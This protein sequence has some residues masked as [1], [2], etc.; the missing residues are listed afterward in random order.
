MNSL[1]TRI[2]LAIIAV[3]LVIVT[4]V[5]F[6]TARITDQAFRTYLLR[7][8]HPHVEDLHRVLAHHY[9]TQGS[10]EGVHTT[11]RAYSRHVGRQPS[12]LRRPEI[13]LTDEKGI[14]IVGTAGIRPGQL[15]PRALRSLGTPIVVDDRTVGWLIVLPPGTQ[16]AR[17]PLAERSFL[18]QIQRTLVYIALLAVALGILL[19]VV[20]TRTITSPLQSLVRAARTL[21]QRDF[22]HRVSEKGPEEVAAVARAFNEMA[23][24]LEAAEKRQR[25][26]IADIAHELRTPLSVLQAN[27]RA[28]LDGVYPL[29]PKEIA[30][31]YDEAR[32]INRLV[33]DLHILALA[34]IGQLPLNKETVDVA[35]L[36]RQTTATFALAAE[37]RGVRVDTEIEPVPLLVDVD[38]DRLAQVVRNLLS[39]ALRH[40][41]KGG[42]ITV[43]ARRQDGHVRLEVRDTGPGIPPEHV[44]HVFDRFWRGDPSRARDTGGSGLGL[45]IAR[46]LV[47]AMGGRI[48]VESQVGKGSTFWIE[49]PVSQE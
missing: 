32:L 33:E 9:R 17:L 31:L 22:H 46:S 8:F 48:G 19:S 13:V 14:V 16:G 27:L 44:S 45:S 34:D 40:T 37:S 38:P 43:C 12:L 15:L 21:S 29:E 41:P 35:E 2:T 49:F 10:W 47:N 26:L 36:I 18:Q 6:S 11:L 28:M 25:Q 30:A 3:V 23:A 5:S 24:A 42:R 1:A 4:L 7:A 20:L 39:N